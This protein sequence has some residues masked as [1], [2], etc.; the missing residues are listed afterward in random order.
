LYARPLPCDKQGC[1]SDGVGTRGDSNYP[2]QKRCLANDECVK[3]CKAS[4][5][6]YPITAVEATVCYNQQIFG[7]AVKQCKATINEAQ[8]MMLLIQGGTGVLQ[9]LTLLFVQ[10]FRAFAKPLTPFKLMVTEQVMRSNFVLMGMTGGSIALFRASYMYRG[11]GCEEEEYTQ[12][13]QVRTMYF[14]PVLVWFLFIVG[15]LIIDTYLQM[16]VTGINTGIEVRNAQYKMNRRFIS[17]DYVDRKGASELQ[18]WDNF[19]DRLQPSREFIATATSAFLNTFVSQT[20]FQFQLTN[21]L[22]IVF[23]SCVLQ[24]CILRAI[25]THEHIYMQGARNIMFPVS[26]VGMLI[27][28]G[29][30]FFEAK[31]IREMVTPSRLKSVYMADCGQ[32]VPDPDVMMG[33]D[34]PHKLVGDYRESHGG[35]EEEGMGVQDVQDDLDDPNSPEFQAISIQRSTSLLQL[36]ATTSTPSHTHT[37]TLTRGVHGHHHH[38]HEGRARDLTEEKTSHKSHGRVVKH[39]KQEVFGKLKV[40]ND[41]FDNKTKF[42]DV[43]DAPPRTDDDV[44]R[45]KKWKLCMRAEGVPL[46]SDDAVPEPNPDQELERY[47]SCWMYSM[48]NPHP[49]QLFRVPRDP[50]PDFS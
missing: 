47:A 12:R 9:S 30:S 6:E 45:C 1:E 42:D 19:Y 43:S 11:K 15:L 38:P 49:L 22:G 17:E 14:M 8:Q 27:G 10:R 39:M 28:L 5:S 20:A 46:L 21:A 36:E 18:L 37:H 3:D 33:V 16:R 44:N 31:K 26:V 23:S 41:E 2:E 40:S 50:P 35:M 7:D 24:E 34:A 13:E 29:Y 25:A 4:C 32:F 48:F